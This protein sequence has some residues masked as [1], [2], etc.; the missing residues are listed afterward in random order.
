VTPAG[1]YWIM[2]IVARIDTKSGIIPPPNVI[3]A[4]QMHNGPTAMSYRAVSHCMR[5][6]LSMAGRE[7][8]AVVHSN[9]ASPDAGTNL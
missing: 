3:V 8:L 9:L 7:L 2:I 6:F 5:R 1:K 4:V